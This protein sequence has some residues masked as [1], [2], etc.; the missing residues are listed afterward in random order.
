VRLLRHRVVARHAHGETVD[1]ADVRVVE[2]ARRDH[3]SGSDPLD[4][5]RFLHAV[6]GSGG[7]F[8]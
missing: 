3:V 1:L 8:G 2:L 4:Q 7:L 5:F 6:S